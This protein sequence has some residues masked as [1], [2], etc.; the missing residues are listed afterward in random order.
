MNFPSIKEITDK[1][2]IAFKR[3]PIVLSWAILGSFYCIYLIESDMDNLFTNKVEELLTISLGVSWL[4]ATQFFIEQLKHPK[5]WQWIHLIVIALLAAFYFHLP[6]FS[7]YENNPI[8]LI[9]FILYL[10][11]GHFFILFAPFLISWNK[12]TYWNYLKS[13]SIALGRSF[14]FSAVLYIG[15]VLALVALEFLFDFDIK[16]E[17]YAQLY[18]FCLGVV[19]TWTYLSDFPKNIQKQTT[20]N[21]NKALEVFVKYI[22]IPLVIVYLII[23]YA[24]SLKIV[25][26]W[27]LPKGWVSYLVTALALL[28]FSIQMMINPVQKTIKSWTINKFYPWFYILLL[29]LI[30][31]LFV[32]I[33]K[34][35][36]EYGFTE[37]RFFILSIAIWILGITV[38]LLL[39]KKKQLRILPMSLLILTLL[40]SFGFWSVFNISKNSQVSHFKSTFNKVLK[41]NKTASSKEYDK[42]E[43]II[44]YL[45]DRE[46]SHL[47]N[48]I[49]DLNVEKIGLN[50]SK[51]S[52]RVYSYNASAKVLDSLKISKDPNDSSQEALKVYYYYY[53]DWN[54]KKNL[55]LN[56]QGFNHFTYLENT[57]KNNSIGN[58]NVEFNTNKNTISL[59]SGNRTAL[60]IPLNKKLQYLSKKYGHDLNAAPKNEFV[61]EASNDSIVVKVIF[62]SLNFYKEKP[63]SNLDLNNARMFL[64]LKQLK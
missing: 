41:N 3:F 43:S 18:I 52:R 29:P 38:Y 20:I 40:S 60:N 12:Y 19:N 10:V 55:N 2:L 4:I 34:R 46:S 48:N 33:F 5:K 36:G 61:I 39:S 54:S 7:N 6:D 1:A 28:G 13:I 56:I 8:F 9:R 35:I 49:V 26:N 45:T 50:K 59:L 42:M 22:L 63:E 21:F 11:G 51:N 62:E 27:N 37:N 15:L 17:A 16:D 44:D 23:L 30:V 64:F 24:Y 57:S 31:L 32:A 53:S 14:L 58:F 25:L 47:L